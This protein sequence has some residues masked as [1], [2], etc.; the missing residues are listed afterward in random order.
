MTSLDNDIK[1]HITKDNLGSHED[2]KL[3]NYEQALKLTP[4]DPVIYNNLGIY[5]IQ[6]RK[7]QKAIKCFKKAIHLNPNF[8]AA[9]SNLGNAFQELGKCQE[10]ASCYHKAINIKPNFAEAII[11]SGIY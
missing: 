10:A 11:I 5:L 3:K 1:K 9:H 7:F 6:V 2:V 4:N 8:D